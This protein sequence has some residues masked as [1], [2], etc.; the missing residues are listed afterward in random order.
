MS[1]NDPRNRTEALSYQLEDNIKLLRASAVISTPEEVNEE[2]K[3]IEAHITYYRQM[4]CIEQ[5]LTG[6]ELAM[7]ELREVREAVNAIG[8]ASYP[9]STTN[10]VCTRV[11]ESINARINNLKK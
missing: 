9:D 1:K 6:K 11:R 5:S 10:R 7:Q 8:S 4:E 2:L 3:K